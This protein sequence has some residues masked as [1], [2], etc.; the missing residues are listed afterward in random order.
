MAQI[1]RNHRLPF[2]SEVGFSDYRIPQLRGDNGDQGFVF[3]DYGALCYRFTGFMGKKFPT[4]SDG[5]SNVSRR[6]SKQVASN[7]CGVTYMLWVSRWI[8]NEKQQ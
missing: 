4:M 5:L 2:G 7:E 6:C 8:V 3:A 1:S